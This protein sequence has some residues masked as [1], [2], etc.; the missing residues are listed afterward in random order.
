MI[1]CTT[2]PEEPCIVVQYFSGLANIINTDSR[3][4]QVKESALFIIDSLVS[5]N[6]FEVMMAR[7]QLSILVGRFYQENKDF[8]SPEQYEAVKRDF[9]YFLALVDLAIEHAKHGAEKN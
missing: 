6:A 8:M 4:I 3:R 7:T 9:E 5:E 2:N 1:L